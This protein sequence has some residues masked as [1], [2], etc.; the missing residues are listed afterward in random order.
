VTVGEAAQNAVILEAVA[1]LA[2]LAIQV[3]NEAEPA[4]RA[5]HDKH[6]LRK[7]GSSA[8]YGQPK[9]KP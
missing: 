2:H 7:H 5:L 3:Q 8:Y 9:D 1:K 6:F 4:G